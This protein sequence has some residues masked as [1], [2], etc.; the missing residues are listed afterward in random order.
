[1]FAWHSKQNLPNVDLVCQSEKNS[2]TSNTSFMFNDSSVAVHYSNIYDK[3]YS[4]IENYDSHCIITCFFF[5]IALLLSISL[6]ILH[7]HMHHFR[8]V[9]GNNR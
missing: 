9:N 1:M 6:Q 7:S 8:E 2:D 5:L 3:E 4:H